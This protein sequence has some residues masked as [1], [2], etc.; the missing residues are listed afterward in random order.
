MKKIENIETRNNHNL[1][2]IID[3]FPH[4]NIKF[5]PFGPNI[6]DYIAMQLSRIAGKVKYKNINDDTKTKPFLS[7][8]L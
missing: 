8:A 6:E 2:V 1:E 7:K 5:N 4:A 3:Y